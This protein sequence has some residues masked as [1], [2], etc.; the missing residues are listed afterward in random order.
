LDR[1]GLDETVLVAHDA[2]GPP[3]IDLA[4]AHPATN[5]VTCGL[6]PARVVD[7]LIR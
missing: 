6:D 3:A 7:D 2:A 5:A 4:L 1:L